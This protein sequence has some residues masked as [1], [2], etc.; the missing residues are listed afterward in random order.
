[1]HDSRSLRIENMYM[2]LSSA[3]IYLGERENAHDLA[4]CNVSVSCCSQ[5]C[6]AAQVQAGWL[7]EAYITQQEKEQI[8]APWGVK[9]RKLEAC[10]GLTDTG[11]ARQFQEKFTCALCRWNRDMLAV[12]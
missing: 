12:L 10:L 4:A 6:P 9:Y 2:R 5:I 11:R 1:M 7:H 3:G 8:L